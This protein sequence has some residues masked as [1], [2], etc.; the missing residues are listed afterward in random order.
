MH[1]RQL[2]VLVRIAAANIGESHKNFRITT[3]RLSQLNAVIK[4]M[5]DPLSGVQ[6]PT[7]FGIETLNPIG[8]DS[9]ESAAIA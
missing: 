3:G 8:S 7:Q 4:K 2:S 5:P 6:H 1:K 9:F